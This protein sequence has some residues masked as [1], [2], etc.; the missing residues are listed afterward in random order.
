VP[1][2]FLQH[3]VY[4]DPA[5]AKRVETLKAEMYRLKK[6]LKDENQFEK[7]PPPD[8]VDTLSK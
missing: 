3:N 8:D 2:I 6:E 5:Y 1:P 4:S 7:K